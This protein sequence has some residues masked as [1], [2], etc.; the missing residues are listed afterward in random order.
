M[1]KVVDHGARRKE[2]IEATWRVIEKHGIAEVTTRRIASESGYSMGVLT[3]YF[4]SKEELLSAALDLSYQNMT[5]RSMQH[6]ADF[7]NLTS[8]WLI[9]CEALPLTKASKSECKIDIAFAG[10]ALGNKTL[11]KFFQDGNNEWHEN[12]SRL[13]R[14]LKKENQMAKDLDLNFTVSE[15]L[16]H[17]EGLAVMGTLNPKKYTAKTIKAS[18]FRKLD[19][20][21]LDTE[22][23][24]FENIPTHFQI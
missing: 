3:H 22:Q 8:L 12:I 21:G 19:S 20:C 1:P 9:L 23:I 6:L 17:V 7:K 10:I 11:L 18:L 15:L 5:N 4:E 16:V 14:Y 13:F 2:L 24:D